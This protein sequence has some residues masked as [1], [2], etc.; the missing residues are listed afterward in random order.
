VF[1]G[2]DGTGDYMIPMFQAF[3]NQFPNHTIILQIGYN[4]VWSGGGETRNDKDWWGGYDDPP[5]TIIEAIIDNIA[6]MDQN[7]GI[8]WV[9]FSL[10]DIEIDLLD[11]PDPGL[12][13]N[14]PL[15][16]NSISGMHIPCNAPIHPDCYD[17]QKYL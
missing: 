16:S 7:I 11:T 14:C 15:H 13:N 1:I 5:E 8:V 12:W 4:D 6:S 2:L 10:E 3:V 17:K 9:D